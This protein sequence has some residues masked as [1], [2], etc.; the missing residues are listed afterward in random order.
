MKFLFQPKTRK[1]ANI[2]I[3]DDNELDTKMLHQEFE[4][5]TKYNVRSFHSGE[6]FLKYLISNP[7]SRKQSTVII[8]DY[9]LSMLNVDAKN[10]IE[11]LKTIREINRDYEVIITTKY[12][13]NEIITDALH[14]GAVNVVKKNENSFIRLDSNIKWIL[15]Q[16]GLRRKRRN[17]I[18]MLVFFFSLTI[19]LSLIAFFSYQNYPQ[20][21]DR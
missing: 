19:L 1:P 9:N 2:F 16:R 8:L 5:R 6:T 12:S 10:G 3:V 18:S 4:L 11:L 7:P 14:F 20:L 21:F 13:D 15:L 17:A